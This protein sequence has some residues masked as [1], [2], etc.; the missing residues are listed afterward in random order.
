EMISKVSL[1]QST[2]NQLPW[3]FEAGTPN[4]A[5]AIGLGAAV[6]YLFEIGIE[7]VRKHEMELTSYAMKRL[8]EIPEVTIYGPYGHV[9]ARSEATKQSKKRLPR[10][11]NSLAMT[12]D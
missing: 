10:S 4:I 2:W 5:G 3:K 6:D 12:N 7:N 1:S 11:L 9:I 8:S